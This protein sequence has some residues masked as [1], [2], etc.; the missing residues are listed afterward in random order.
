MLSTCYVV[1][2]VVLSLKCAQ[3]GV[4]PETESGVDV[5]VDCPAGKYGKM[6]RYC[7]EVS[8]N[9]TQWDDPVT[10]YCLDLVPA[11]GLANIDFVFNVSGSRTRFIEYN[12]HGFPNGIREAYDVK[13]TTVSV[14]R[15][16]E[17]PNWVFSFRIFVI[18]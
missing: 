10:T 2:A 8:E 13:K 14:H 3:D 17:E 4:W 6:T 18:L 15:I 1:L 12:S 5:A 16:T 7:H 9:V 11:A